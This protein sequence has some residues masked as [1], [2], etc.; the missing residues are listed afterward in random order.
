MAIVS[1]PRQ[2]G[3]TTLA[4]NIRKAENMFYFNWD[5]DADREQL[6]RGGQSIAEN[7]GLNQLGPRK[8]LVVFDEIHK[9][10]KWKR[11]V[12]G[13]YDRYGKECHILITGSARMDA[14]KKGGD[15][16]MGRYFSYRLHPFSVGELLNRPLPQEELH[17][18]T[19]LSHSDF[20]WV[21]NTHNLI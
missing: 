3:K 11:F 9:F 18:P 15:S 2:V 14:F 20:Q 5:D 17:Q 8:S 4:R 12:K 21:P 1:G 16:L 19:E 13:F 10:A 6:L 7:I